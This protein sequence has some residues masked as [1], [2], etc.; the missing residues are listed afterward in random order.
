LYTK[1][2]DVSRQSKILALS[3]KCIFNHRPSIFSELPG[4]ERVSGEVSVV[5]GAGDFSQLQILKR[6]ILILLVL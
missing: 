2:P 3:L 5:E 4:R 1:S 6:F